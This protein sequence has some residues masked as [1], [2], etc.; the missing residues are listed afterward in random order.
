MIFTE[1]IAIVFESY[2]EH[3][4]NRVNKVDLILYLHISNKSNIWLQL[5]YLKNPHLHVSA[6]RISYHKAVY[7]FNTRG[8]G[9]CSKKSCKYLLRCAYSPVDL[10]DFS[11][12]W[13]F[14]FF[15]CMRIT[16]FLNVG[17]CKI[18]YVSNNVKKL[19]FKQKAILR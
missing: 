1:S 16:Y 19:E 12:C 8:N 18:L 15:S 14:P 5:V 17:F 2:T 10:R 7:I 9:T 3:T 11:G 6:F 13:I 4:K